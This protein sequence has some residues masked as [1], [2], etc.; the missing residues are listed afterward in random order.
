MKTTSV[1]ITYEN[2]NIIENMISDILEGENTSIES[3]EKK[4]D[5]MI[6]KMI[7]GGF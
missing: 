5:S 3:R 4:I 6:N 2:E 7:S 1:E